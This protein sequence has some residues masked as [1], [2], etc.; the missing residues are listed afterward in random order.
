M[1][2]ILLTLLLVFCTAIGFSQV[3]FEGFEN[4]TGPD[5]SPSTNWTLGSGNWAVF[6]NNVGGTVNWSTNANSYSGT[7]CAYMTRQNIGMGITSEEY[8]ATPLI[9]VPTNGKLQFYSRSFTAGNQGTFY[10]VK[11][12][13]AT[14]PQNVPSSYTI[15]LEELGEDQLCPNYEMYGKKTYDLSAFAGQNIYIAFVRKHTQPNASISGDRFLLDDVSVIAG[16]DC[17][18]PSDVRVSYSATNQLYSMTWNADTAT[19]WEVAVIP[20]FQG[21][22]AAN[23]TVAVTTTNSFTYPSLNNNFLNFCVR[24]ICSNGAVSGWSITT[25]YFPIPPVNATCTYV[26][27][28]VD[29]N[30]N[31]SPNN[32]PFFLKV[33]YSQELNNSGI[34][35]YS[36]SNYYSKRYCE[37]PPNIADYG[38]QILPE[39]APYYSLSTSSYNDIP[40][41]NQVLEFPVVI[42][43]PLNDLD[44]T[45]NLIKRPRPGMSYTMSIYYYNRGSNPMSAMLT[46]IKAPLTTIQSVHPSFLNVV[47]N[48]N[49]F[50][51]QTET[52]QPGQGRIFYVNLDVPSIPTVSIGDILNHSVSL[53][54]FSATDFIPS[55]N[56]FTLSTPIVGSYDPNNKTE[57][58]GGKI[59]F[60]QFTNDDYLYYTINFQNLGNASAIDVRIE[61]VLDSKLDETT[62]QMIESSHNYYMDRTANNLTWHFDNIQ[63]LPA[64]VNDDLSKGFVLFKVKPK[65]GYAVGDIIPNTASI[66]FDS[67]PAIVTNTFNT[68][69]VQALGTTSFAS[70]NVLLFPNPANNSIQISLQNTAETMDSIS[71]TDIS[72]KNIRNLKSIQ[73]NQLTIDVSELAKGIYFVEIITQN[74]LK[75]TKKIIKE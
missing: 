63:L 54:S 47:L 22:P 52:L 72:G 2:K 4:T 8:L 56:N 75:Q 10:Q 21:I 3:L 59:L 43:Q 16:T 5:P 58:H 64:F 55:N 74:G 49:G 9:T 51:Y 66:Y 31:G 25:V 7:Y 15:L 11:V 24:R 73:S 32:E 6:D 38:C 61:D 42:S 46:F 18:N 65:S 41:I 53:S 28:F 50:T 37:N 57:S 19:A 12:A 29:Y 17:D 68:E 44:I 27:S 20:A 14:S 1:K 33:I 67:N 34:V 30:N 39:Y 13:M 62:V 23:E 60:D 48:S 70:N 26:R 45:M 71:I 40:F 35:S 36:Q 69:F